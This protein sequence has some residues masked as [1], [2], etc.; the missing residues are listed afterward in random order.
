MGVFAPSAERLRMRN[1]ESLFDD[2]LPFGL[3][4]GLIDD[5]RS[6]AVARRRNLP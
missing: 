6:G 2:Y 5:T 3:E 1:I 4:A